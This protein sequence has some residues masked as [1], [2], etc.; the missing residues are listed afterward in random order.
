MQ[1]ANCN[2]HVLDLFGRILEFVI[3]GTDIGFIQVDQWGSN[4]SVH[5]QKPDDGKTQ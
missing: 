5:H 3:Y 1:Q 2:D 4:F